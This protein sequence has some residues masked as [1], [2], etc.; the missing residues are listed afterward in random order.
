MQKGK[1]NIMRSRFRLLIGTSLCVALLSSP[2]LAN[3]VREIQISGAQRIE[4]ATVLTYL[5]LKKGDEV[6]QELLDES[7]KS[8]FATGLFA[9]VQLSENNGVVNVAVT[10]NPIINQIAFE[11]NDEIKDE[12]LLSEISLRPRQVFTRTKVQNDV[13]RLYELYRRSG[14]YSAVVEPKIIKLD[15]NRV[16]LVFE[17]TEGP[18]TKIAT[19]RF[20]G[21]ERY[22]D[23]ELRSVLAS[24]EERWYNFLTSNDRYDAD[25]LAFDQELLRKFYL[26]EG[27]ADFR[28]LSAVSELSKDKKDFFITMTIDEGERYRI[29]NVKINSQ[30][31][32]LDPTV[33]KKNVTFGQNTWYNAEEV[34]ASA[35][36]MTT[37]LGDLQYAFVTVAPDVQ[38]NR[39]KKTVDIV[40]NI[41]ESPR[42]FVERIN[43][44]GNSRTLDK[45]IRREFELSEGDAFNRRKLTKSEQNIKDLDF[46][47]K[48]D[49]KTLPG[50]APD[51]TVVDVSVA[52]K[53]TGELSVGAGFSTAD[54]PLA[55]FRIRERNF[56]GKG[57]E[58]ELASTIAGKRTE[59]DVSFTEP[60]FMDR[61][62]S[63]G[64]DAFHI[65]RDQQDESSFDQRRTGGGFRF[66][67]P[68]SDKWR[69]TWRYRIEQNDITNVKSDASRFI[70]DQEGSRF[71]SAISQ[72]IVYDDL[73]SRVFPTDGLTSWIETEL[74]GVGGDAK[75]VSGKVGAAYYYPIAKQWTFSTTGEVAAIEGWSDDTVRIN[76]RFFLGG[77]KLRGFDTAG[78][79]PRDL[80]TDDSLGGNKYY[81]GSVELRFPIGF[82][83]EMGV[84]GHAFSDVGSLWSLNESG[85]GI[86]DENTPRVSAGV[87]FSWRSPF[88][89]LRIDLA[90]PLLKED[91][92]KDQLF[93]FS[94]GTRF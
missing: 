86:V 36:N 78:V 21:N 53:S 13:T 69:Q 87:G 49:V 60:Y 39:E 20:V 59:F 22:N 12:S 17:I 93:R 89:P 4:P 35:D 3:T 15:Q 26:K 94:F 42:V 47:E 11:G 24:S 32:N 85:T 92:D 77:D 8:L 19:I 16:N 67:Y 62:L 34:K 91:Y 88:G 5:P 76:E 73:D 81:R 31:R 25:R 28:I 80:T 75:Y 71:T 9:D 7:L 90:E 72:R 48:V 56:L 82:P 79:G 52:E 68:L 46:F 65:T 55:D 10:E 14:Q 43:I 1:T 50:S 45:V 70:Q 51:K 37:H 83:E 33:L 38:R 29:G 58:L 61:D 40:F 23:E 66:G 41:N 84:Y 57:Q 63:A 18:V 2:T 74:A 6:T 30:I 44:E 54:G 64:I 27:Y